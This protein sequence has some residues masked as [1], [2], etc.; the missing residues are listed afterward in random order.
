[1]EVMRRG[2]CVNTIVYDTLRQFILFSKFEALSF[3]AGEGERD[4]GKERVQ[5][6]SLH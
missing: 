3:F 6:G 4:V 1:M 2:R 5:S